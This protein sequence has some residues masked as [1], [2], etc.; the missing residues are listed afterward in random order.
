MKK[1]YKN[2]KICTKCIYDETVPGISFDKEGICNYCHQVEDLKKIYK[3]GT[4]EGIDEFNKIVEEIKYNGKD[5]EY[6][7]VI[8]VSGGTDSSYMLHLAKEYGL[9]PLAVHYDNTWN[10]SIANENIRKVTSKLSI[11]LFTYVVDN[12]EADDLFRSFIKAGVPEVDAPT[13][14][15]LAEVLYRA[16]DKY[17]IKYVF[18]G[19]SFIAEGVAPMSGS[20]MDGRYIESIHKQFGKIKKLKSFPN[21]KFFTFMKWVVVKKIK[22]IRP[23]WYIDYSKQEAKEILKKEYD[24]QDYG[25]HHLE[26]RISIF[27]HAYNLPRRFKKDQRNNSLSAQVRAGLKS[28]EEAIKEYFETEPY[29]EKDLLENMYKRLNFTKEEFF[30][31]LNEPVKTFR[32]YPTYKKR[33]EL[34]RPLFKILAK[35]NL[36]PMS[37]YLKYC[38]PMPKDDKK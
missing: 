9:R 27:G 3:T 10:T 5:K 17:G 37:F 2:L 34:L 13:D 35:A 11:D 12:K 25:G 18:E 38:F 15:A 31:I 26:N 20:Y 32:D 36:V 24:W 8:G 7:I 1:D 23:L 30:E 19:H 21:M 22:K 16:A 33:F 28:R 29:M 4:K 14:I 6:D